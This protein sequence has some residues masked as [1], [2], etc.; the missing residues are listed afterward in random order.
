MLQYMFNNRAYSML[1]CTYKDIPSHIERVSL[2]WKQYNVDIP[3]QQNMM[4]DS[5]DENNAFQLVDSNNECKAY[6][7]LTLYKPTK[8]KCVVMW[9]ERKIYLSI[10]FYFLKQ[11]KN[12][13]YLY[14]MP[15]TKEFIPFRTMLDDM[16]VKSFIRHGTPIGID[17]Y[18]KKSNNLYKYYFERLHVYEVGTW[19]S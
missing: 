5:I 11:H 6:I 16:Q 17:F 7:Y 2:Y 1:N 4:E 18:S 10:L 19:V 3:Y 15:H 14:F 9:F 13:H 8:Y 12:L